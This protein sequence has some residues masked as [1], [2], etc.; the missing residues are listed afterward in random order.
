MPGKAAGWAAVELPWLCPHTESLIGLAEQPSRLPDLCA[1]DPALLVFLLRFGPETGNQPGLWTNT[2]R[3]HSATLPE[4]AASY[5]KTHPVGWLDR[6]NASIHQINLVS[7]LASHLAWELA[8]HITDVSPDVVSVAARLAPLGWYAVAAVN[9]DAVEQCLNEPTF[10][11]HPYK[12][13]VSVWGLEHDAISRR[14]AFRW[15]FPTWLSSLLGT[16]NLPIRAATQLVQDTTHLA[17][18]Q[19]AVHYA[20]QRIVD[21][22]LTRH[23]DHEESL[24][25]IGLDVASCQ[26]LLKSTPARL[27]AL[28]ALQLPAD[29]RCVPVLNNLLMMAGQSRR[30]NGASLVCRIEERADQLHHAI[31]DLTQWHE[32]RIRDAKLSALAEFAAGAGHEINNPLAVIQGNAQ[33]LLRT[34]QDPAREDALRMIVKQTHRIA[35]IL[36]DMMQFARPAKPDTQFISVIDL[37]QSVRDELQPIAQER[38]VSLDLLN[39]PSDIWCLADLKQ[40]RTILIGVIRNAVEAVPNE[41]WVRLS[42]ERRSTGIELAIEDSGPG[43]DDE[44]LEHAFDPFYC[45]RTA[46]RGRGLGLPVAWSL[47]RINGGDVRHE[48]VPGGPTRFVV[49]LPEATDVPPPINRKTA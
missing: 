31:H 47:A 23:M 49:I 5:L 40:L 43:M 19:L 28:P 32:T 35:S 21:L 12:T 8:K 1:H 20:E 29:P 36:R 30:R 22:A 14:L 6:S 15:R 25:Q 17:V 37:L 18:V 2:D 39:V 9:P 24:R 10:R 46:G 41:G 3:F 11:L 13:Q 7:L 45:G 48:S 42:C 4:L 33:R 34:E 38:N 26:A 27:D 16:L 44:M